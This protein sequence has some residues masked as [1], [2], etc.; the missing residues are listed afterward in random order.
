MRWILKR[1]LLH[2][3]EFAIYLYVIKVLNA[4]RPS[5]E[6]QALHGLPFMWK[7]FGVVLDATNRP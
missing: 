2:I 3:K 1:K 6:G 5:Q 4:Q 7:P